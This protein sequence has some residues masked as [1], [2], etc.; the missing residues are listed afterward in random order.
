VPLHNC[1]SKLVNLALQLLLYG[2]HDST[3]QFACCSELQWLLLLL[4]LLVNAREATRHCSTHGRSLLCLHAV[5]AR[6][7]RALRL[8]L[9]LLLHVAS[10]HSI[11]AR[12]CSWQ[13]V[14]LLVAHT[15]T[16]GLNVS[17]DHGLNAA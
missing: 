1:T 10:W 9:T 7:S 4:L 14:V 6:A 8:R 15:G 17:S 2:A 3:Q 11:A 12:S 5:G 13:V 16:D